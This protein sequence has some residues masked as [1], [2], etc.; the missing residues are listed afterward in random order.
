[1]ITGFNPADM[2]A[3]NLINRHPD[4][5]LFGTIG[6]SSTRRDPGQGLGDRGSWCVIGWH[7][8]VALCR[9]RLLAVDLNTVPAQARSHHRVEPT[10]PLSC[11][12]ISRT[13]GGSFGFEPGLRSLSSS[14]YCPILLT[15]AASNVSRRRPS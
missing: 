1:M 8:R 6:V 11:A 5:F 4:R 13:E 12:I 15:R 7:R 14:P 2:Y 9:V 3:A 10:R